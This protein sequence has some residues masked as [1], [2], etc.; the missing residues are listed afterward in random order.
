LC[1]AEDVSYTLQHFSSSSDGRIITVDGTTGKVLWDRNF[2]NPIVAMYLLE[3][4]GL[5]RLPFAIIG[6]ETLDSFAQVC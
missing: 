4:D 1:F 2:G 5:H 3:G 6:V